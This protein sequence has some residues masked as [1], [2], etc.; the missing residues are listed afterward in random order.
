MS[1][2]RP[3][4]WEPG[5]IN[6]WKTDEH[7]KPKCISCNKCYDAIQ[8]TAVAEMGAVILPPMPAF[9]HLPKTIDEIIN[10]TVGKSLCSLSSPEP[11][12]NKLGEGRTLFF[13][14]NFLP[15][16]PSG[17]NGELIWILNLVRFKSQQLKQYANLLPRSYCPST[18]IGTKLKN[19]P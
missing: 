3:L 2:C 13:I 19:F 18:N 12:S 8:L 1:L 16:A 15:P 14:T 17:G 9:Y 6:E 11:D 5:L 7:K 4:I 10:Q